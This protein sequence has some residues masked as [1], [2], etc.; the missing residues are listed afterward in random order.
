MLFPEYRPRRMRQNEAFRRMIRETVL[1]VND[2][3]LPLFA[4]DGKKAEWIL[5]NIGTMDQLVE[6]VVKTEARSLSRN[7]PKKYTA[8]QLY[9]EQVFDVQAEIGNTLQPIFEENG[10][11]LDEFLLRKIDFTDDDCTSAACS[12]N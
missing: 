11:I 12:H 10:I 4:I 1:S 8:A 9:S 6:K 3:I 5:N 2:L 7:I